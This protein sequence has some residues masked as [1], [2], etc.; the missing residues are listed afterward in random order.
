MHRFPLDPTLPATTV[1]ACLLVLGSWLGVPARA[2]AQESTWRAREGLPVG[3]EA[4]R[5]LRVLQ[6]AGKAPLY[7][8]TLRGFTPRE[9]S[10]VLPDAEEHPW[11]HRLDFTLEEPQGVERGWVLPEAGILFNSAYPFGEN[12]GAVWAGKGFTGI[13]R[14]G[15]YVRFGP[16]HLRVAP[17]A[18]WAQNASFELANNGLPD[19]GAFRDGRFPSW[20]DR[21][22]RFG[23]DSYGR[24]GLGS[25]AI[26]L[27]L[28]GVTV[29]VSAAG[30]QWGP[31]L[32]Y[33]LLM[34]NNA[35]GFPHLFL[36]TA[37]PVNL[38]LVHLHGRFVVGRLDQSGLSPVQEGELRRFVSAAV[39]VLTPR[40]L[41]GLE[42]GV[43]RFVE[44]IW[45]EEGI[46]SEDI[47]RP[48]TGVTHD[49]LTTENPREENQLASA[50]LR[51]VI[52]RAGMEVYGE[53]IREDFSRD[54]RHNLEEPD[55]L[56]S[57]VIGFQRVWA[58][59]GNRLVALRGAVVSA[60]VHHSERMDR[61]RVW[62][63][64]LLPRYIHTGV[65]QGHT[66]N[67]QILGSPT[68]YGGSGWTLGV[69]LYGE[70]GRWTVD[71]SRALRTDWLWIHNG[72]T[73]PG[74]ADVIYALKL[75]AVRF[76]EGYEWVAVVTPSLNLNRNVEE[77]NHVFNVNL[78]F[79]V[80]GLPW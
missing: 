63:P 38:W 54:L 25:S 16:L 65:A 57:R 47:F 21:P 31:A 28:P 23:N 26:H 29:G 49:H 48:F 41:D 3:S 35:G 7:P 2:L 32:H 78:G 50:F 80:R 64:R 66:H 58:R 67:G 71:F 60:E 22:Q 43:A 68:V 44:S 18:F 15:G 9:I 77:G 45:P 53:L 69:D 62:A 46:R 52:P 79:T 11:R 14:G 36:Q 75:E 55:D 74:I 61:F 56:L 19:D 12:D 34:G 51:W 72:T 8:W 17:E 59:T 30:Q 40:T 73:G 5:Y 37:A 10:R 24:L 76:R 20:I 39:L 33:P 13:V 27:A 70:E 1:L 42:L 6:V 4:E